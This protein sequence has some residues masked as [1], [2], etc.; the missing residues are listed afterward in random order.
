LESLAL[1]CQAFTPLTAIDPPDGILLDITGCAHLFGGEAGLR[2]RLAD[3]V[4][5]ARLAIADT[6]AAAW[7]LAHYGALDAQLLAPLPLAALRVSDGV[8][9]R[10][11][12]LGIRRIGELARLSRG[13]IRAG[14]GADLLLKLDRLLGRAP[15]ALRFL[16]EPAAWREAEYHAEPL[17]AASQLQ[18][19]LGRLTVRLCAALAEAEQGLTGLIV[20]FHR[21]D[22]SLIEDRIGFAAPTR[23]AAHIVRLLA[24]RLCGIDPGFGVEALV[25]T[26]EAE[27]LA[28]AQVE[29]GGTA[30]PRYAQTIDRLMGRARLSRFVPDQ[31]HIPEYA[32]HR[33]PVTAAPAAFPTVPFPRPLRLFGRPEPI[34]VIAPVPD[35]PPRLMQWRGAHHRVIRATGPERIARDWWRHDPPETRPEAERIRDYYVIEDETGQRFWVFR[36]GLH[37]G[38]AVPQWFIHGLF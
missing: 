15:E 24:E 37:T 2:A 17:L 27:P 21:V 18:A 1:W 38:V 4:P 13:E 5:Q 31:T 8:I 14:F 9:A 32:A 30:A 28:M 25:L 29:L 23:D 12:R 26:A 10:L 19:A 20:G 33:V 11:R 35:D 16:T 6:A 3:L 36:A 22:A 34:T 7:A